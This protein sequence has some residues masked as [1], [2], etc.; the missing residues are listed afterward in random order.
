MGDR[1]LDASVAQATARGAAWAAAGARGVGTLGGVSRQRHQG[2]PLALVALLAA[3]L[4]LLLLAPEARAHPLGAG[5]PPTAHLAADGSRVEIAWTAQEDDVADLAEHLGLVPEGTSE[6]FLG[7]VGPSPLDRSERAALSA[8]PALAQAFADGVAVEQDGVACGGRVD[9]ADDVLADG[10]SFEFSCPERVGV[11]DVTIDLLHDVDPVYRTVGLVGDDPPEVETVFTQSAPRHSVDLSDGA[12]RSGIE[13]VAAWPAAGADWFED[14]MVALAD[15]D[16]GWAGGLLAMLGAALVGAAHALGPGHAKTV[17]AAYLGGGG[18]RAR[19]AAAVGGVVA[20]MHT[21]T[22][23]ALAAALVL[24]PWS[25]ELAPAAGAALTTTAGVVLVVLGASM[26]LRRHGRSGGHD[27]PHDHLHG[28]EHRSPLSRGGLLALGAAGGLLPSPSALLV[29]STTWVAGRPGLGLALVG[30]FGVGL[31]CTI[32]GVGLAAGAGRRLL[33]RRAAAGGRLARLGAVVPSVA[34]G[35][36]T[37]GG[38]WLA[39]AGVM[40]LTSG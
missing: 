10:V 32:A 17:T 3:A 7:M 5:P 25:P 11:V 16:V 13:S 20:L 19:H 9:V 40:Q 37:A 35:V 21:A 29:L 24:L 26:L 1:G 30:A 33:D 4:A 14:R 39:G 22:A 23:L 27:H 2:A 15:L 8:E 6:A 34:A 38:L 28:S 36:V 18:A 12:A 31:A